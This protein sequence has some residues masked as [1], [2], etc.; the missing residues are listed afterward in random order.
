MQE[1]EPGLLH[2][3]RAQRDAGALG[4]NFKNDLGMKQKNSEERQATNMVHLFH[5][6]AC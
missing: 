2:G 4:V 6:E 3:L 1:L 5:K